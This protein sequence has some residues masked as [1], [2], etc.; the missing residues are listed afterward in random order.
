[1]A[2]INLNLGLLWN[3][4]IPSVRRTYVKIDNLSQFVRRAKKIFNLNE[5]LK[6]W[7]SKIEKHERGNNKTRTKKDGGG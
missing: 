6:Y 1:M 4:V 7:F 2:E 3:N 5:T